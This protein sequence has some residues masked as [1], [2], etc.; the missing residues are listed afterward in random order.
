MASDD[1]GLV[2]AVVH[3]ENG[4]ITHPIPTPISKNIKTDH[5]MYFRRSSAGLRLKNPNAT[6]I[7]KANS[8]MDWKWLKCIGSYPQ[9][10]RPRA[11][12]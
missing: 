11:A 7:A 4:Y 8:S 9:A 10:F 6:E 3:R 12:S 1:G 2:N 5:P